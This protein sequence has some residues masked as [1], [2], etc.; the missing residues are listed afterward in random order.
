MTGALKAAGSYAIPHTRIQGYCVYTN[1][2]P[3]GYF[4]AP[5][6]AQT[7][8][9]V[10]SYVDFIADMLGL[11]PLAI[12]MRNAPQKGDTRAT[13]ESLED[14]HCKEV[15]TGVAQLSSWSKTRARH[16]KNR[17]YG[18]RMALGDRHVGNRRIELR[19]DS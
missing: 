17:L 11:D 9:A 18:R 19:A 13:G 2:V 1:Q 10:E 6:E 5:G 15:L 16:N 14:P 3:C 4:R 8:F 12:R 7:L